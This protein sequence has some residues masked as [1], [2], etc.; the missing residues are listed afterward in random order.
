MLAESS[1]HDAAISRDD[2]SAINTRLATRA[3]ATADTTRHMGLFVSA[4][5][6]AGTG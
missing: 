2:L 4:G 5:S 6:L 1:D 3:D